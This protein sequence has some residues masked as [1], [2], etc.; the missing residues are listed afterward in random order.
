MCVEHGTKARHPPAVIRAS[1]V[2]RPRLNSHSKGPVASVPAHHAGRPDF[3]KAYLLQQYTERTAHISAAELSCGLQRRGEE[4]RDA[5]VMVI[6]TKEQAPECT[7]IAAAVPGR[8]LR[9]DA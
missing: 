9:P 8:H 7:N 2:K 1:L 6:I 3:S 5:S 4:G